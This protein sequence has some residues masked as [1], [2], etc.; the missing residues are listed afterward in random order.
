MLLGKLPVQ[1]AGQKSLTLFV[2]AMSTAHEQ[3]Q[4]LRLGIWLFGPLRSLLPLFCWHFVSGDKGICSNMLQY[5][6][7]R[8]IYLYKN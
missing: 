7:F 3:L 2:A 5:V 1:W 4:Q 6:V 8:N